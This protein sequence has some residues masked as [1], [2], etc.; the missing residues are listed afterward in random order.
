MHK[1]IRMSSPLLNNKLT[2]RRQSRIDACHL[3]VMVAGLII[4]ARLT[5][6]RATVSMS[7]SAHEHSQGGSFDKT[8][9][10]SHDQDSIK[11][12]VDTT[13]RSHDSITSLLGSIDLSDCGGLLGDEPSHRYSSGIVDDTWL[14][15][16]LE[17]EQ[18][19]DLEAGGES[20]LNNLHSPVNL[21]LS[22]LEAVTEV[23]VSC[24]CRD[25]I[26]LSWSCGTVDSIELTSMRILS[27]KEKWRGETDFESESKEN[28]QSNQSHDD[29]FDFH[30]SL[31]I[32]KRRLR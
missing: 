11:Q 23:D 24:R 4:K 2:N 20:D 3:S 21:V 14:D 32:Y 27:M 17:S 19:H 26:I 9:P 18:H 10:L 1:T 7:E 30:D 13:Y 5:N 31:K 22:M 8:Y 29:L 25:S 16:F 6:E 28:P 15:S 12:I